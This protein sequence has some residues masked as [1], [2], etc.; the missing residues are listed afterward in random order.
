[1]N[2]V[3]DVVLT[4]GISRLN[5]LERSNLAVAQKLQSFSASN[6]LPDEGEAES[7]ASVARRAAPPDMGVELVTLTRNAMS[8]S[9][10]SRAL[11]NQLG[12]YSAVISE[13]RS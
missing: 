13:G 11:S 4:S 6:P 10:I 5:A 8:Y 2:P 9:F 1:M 3:S 7:S 12:L